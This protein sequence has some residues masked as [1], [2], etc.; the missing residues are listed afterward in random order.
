LSYG[1]SEREYN[2]RARKHNPAKWRD[3]RCPVSVSADT[4]DTRRGG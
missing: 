1:R 3:G 4:D 2:G